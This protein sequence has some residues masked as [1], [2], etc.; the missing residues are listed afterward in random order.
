M[1]SELSLRASQGLHYY[2]LIGPRAPSPPGE[3]SRVRPR[4]S[5]KGSIRANPTVQHHETRSLL[6]VS[7][8]EAQGVP[9]RLCHQSVEE[10]AAQLA[11]CEAGRRGGDCR[12]DGLQHAQDLVPRRLGCVHCRTQQ[13]LPLQHVGSDCPPSPR[14]A[15]RSTSNRGGLLRHDMADQSPNRTGTP[16]HSA[17]GR[18]AS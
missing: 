17:R 15:V 18:A 10:R 12:V 7:T 5:H 13:L 8:F 16:T 11:S 1:Q 9:A 14:L 4:H 3:L 2:A 6:R